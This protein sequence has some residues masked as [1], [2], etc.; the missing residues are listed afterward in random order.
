MS[1]I[2]EG[3]GRKIRTYRKKSGMT[4]QELAD[5]ICKSKAT[6]SKYEKGEI[7]LDLDTLY[8]LS[9]ALNVTAEQLLLTRPL[10]NA[11]SDGYVPL[12]FRDITKFYGYFYDG[13]EKQIVRCLFMLLP[14]E[15]GHQRV[16]MYMNFT[17]YDKHQNCENTYEGYMEHYDAVTNMVLINDHMPMERASIQVL[18]SSLH[19]SRKWGLWNGLSTRPLMPIATKILLANRPVEENEELIA[20]LKISTEDIKLFRLY[21]MFPVF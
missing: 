14:M 20:Q 3:I 12:F 18:A 21:N 1:Q 10:H 19:A 9:E 13:R 4:I 16:R 7:S 6:V 11:D 8:D 17:D 2:T 5:R 15:D